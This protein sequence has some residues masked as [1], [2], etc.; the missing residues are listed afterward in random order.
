MRWSTRAPNFVVI[1]ALIALLSSSFATLSA[2]RAT[3]ADPAQGREIRL[4]HRPGKAGPGQRPFR[5]VDVARLPQGASTPS[6]GAALV[7]PAPTADE[8]PA[9]V[10][11][12]PAAPVQ[13][14]NSSTPA[15]A[16]PTA[17]AGLASSTVEPPD[18][19]VAAGPDHIVQVAATG[20]RMT[21][22]SGTQVAL[23]GLKD[24]FGLTATPGY[25]AE[26]ANPRVIFDSLH[27]RW[28]AIQTS[29]DCYPDPDPEVDADI[30]TGYIDVA[31]S[32]TADPTGSWGVLSLPYPDIV[33]DDPAI[34]TST[35]K[36]V[37]TA[38]VLSLEAGGGQFGCHA[39]GFIGSELDVMAWSELLGGGDVS[40]DFW[41]SGFAPGPV[42]PNIYS[43]WRPARATPATSE[44]VHVIARRTDDGVAYMRITGNPAGE[45]SA[46]F[47]IRN[48]TFNGIAAPFATPPDPRQPGA[49]ATITDAVDG[50]PTDAVWQN[51]RLVF[52]STYPCDPNGGAVETR[53]CVR[54]T[55]LD[56]TTTLPTLAQD[57]LVAQN[58]AD[59]YMGGAALAGNGDLHVVWTRSSSAAGQYPSS[60]TAVQLQGDSPNSLGVR[61]TI[62]AGTGTYPGTRWGD[63]IGVAQD[64]QVPNAVWQANQHSVGASYWATRVSQLQTEGSS[65]TPITPIRVLDSRAAYGTGLTGRFEAN[66]PRSWQVAGVGAI[67]DDAIAVTG[68]VTI[69]TQTAGGYLAVTP[70]P[71]A[72]P[73]SSTINFPL[74]DT[75][76][77]NV[78]VPLSTTGML[79]ATFKAPGGKTT[80]VIF[81]VTGYFKAGDADGTYHAMDPVRFLD[82]RPGIGIGLSGRFASS[83][84]RMLSVAGTRGVPADAVA[85]TGNLTVVHQTKAG[86]VSVTKTSNVNPATSTINFPA[87][88]T[89]ANGVS[90]PLNA[91]GDLWIVYK[92]AAGSTT[93]IILDVTGYYLNDPSG[94]LFY[95]LSP[96]RTLDSRPGVALSG[97]TGFFNTGVPRKLVAGG[98]WGVPDG[99]GAITGNLTVVGQTAAGFVSVTL[100]N[101][102][103]PTTSNLNFPLGDTRANGITVPLAGG[104]DAWIVYKASTSGKRTHLILDVSGYFE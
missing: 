50:R 90:V 39:G 74:G 100:T 33:P 20:V 45:G 77:N 64:P 17:Y 79:S 55:E 54:V 56:T 12:G 70:D 86:Y 98:H 46:F 44:T 36:V 80:D 1:I 28:V 94:M 60:Q 88:D 96:G 102:P 62:A 65:Y 73:P 11:G 59:L 61:S 104:S 58:N 29:F 21:D 72:N 63:Y 93:D 83:V 2:P 92:A 51:D 84:P 47:Q 95:P 69:T 24:F 68:N 10:A 13:A 75:R 8:S 32:L 25:N 37:V 7:A 42:F 52:T 18:S 9:D 78:T 91:T 57:F 26:A 19:G 49:P 14:A 76:A 40:V 23:V 16:E 85:I 4:D 35:D 34:G 38:D 89:R 82:S 30:G 67:P 41:Y 81:D 5:Q 66:L 103:N 99:A 53:D 6:A 22:R 101:Q 31:Y 71:N 43:S 87:G 27:G 15:A 3:A 48:L 97:L